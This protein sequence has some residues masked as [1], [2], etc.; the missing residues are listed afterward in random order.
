[1][2]D[3][4]IIAVVTVILILIIAVSGCISPPIETPLKTTTTKPAVVQP[5]PKI[6]TTTPPTYVTISTPHM[7]PEPTATVTYQTLPTI[8]PVKED[9]VVI[10]S[11][12]N[13][14]FAFNKT[15]VSFDLKNPPMLIDFQ[16]SDTNITRN[17]T[18]KSRILTNEWT[19]NNTVYYDPTAYFEV[20]VREKSTGN[21]VLQDGF[22]QSKQYGTENPR[23]LKIYSTGNYLIEFGGNKV[24]ANINLSVKRE[25][26]IK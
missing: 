18:G 23:H 14:P 8:S 15:A 12:K 4:I 26:N 25:G 7:T 11:T 3:K 17:I 10:Y 6:T 22:G 19:F 21:I 5:T 24:T 20:T 2:N 1:M 13:Q 9:Y 16:L